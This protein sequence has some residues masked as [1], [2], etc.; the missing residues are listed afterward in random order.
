MGCH[1]LLQCMTVKSES[2]VAQWYPTHELWPARLLHP[3][4]FPG[5]STGVGTIAFSTYCPLEQFKSSNSYYWGGEPQ[6]TFLQNR[7]I[8]TVNREVRIH[9]CLTNIR[10]MLRS[11]TAILEDV[12]NTWHN[13]PNFS[14]FFFFDHKNINR[15]IWGLIQGQSDLT[16]GQYLLKNRQ[17]NE[18][19]VSQ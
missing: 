13:L 1:F 12:S 15:L 9:S 16:V 19:N 14:T 5:K 2:E 17:Q 10:S 7:T 3:W 11:I 18:S 4:D 6:N 8:G